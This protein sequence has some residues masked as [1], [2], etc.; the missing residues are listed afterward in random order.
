MNVSFTVPGDIWG[1][2]RPRAT[3]R[4]GF[5]RLY[6]DE[7]TR[8]YERTVGVLAKVAM[9][10]T[11]PLI[12]PLAGSFVFRVEPPRSASKRMRADMLAGRLYPAKKPDVSNCLKAVEDGMNGVVYEDDAQLVLIR[13]EKKYSLT[14]GVDILIK[15]MPKQSRQWPE[16]T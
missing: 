4:G 3:A 5:A 2:G 12:G 7:R 15:P 14:A 6:T 9:G 1:K 8:A 16:S 10:Q 11:A 13:L